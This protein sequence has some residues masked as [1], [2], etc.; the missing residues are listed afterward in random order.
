MKIVV[1][2]LVCVFLL[3]FS[4]GMIS[5]AEQTEDIKQKIN[6]P[7]KAEKETSITGER[8]DLILKVFKKLLDQASRADR[9]DGVEGEEDAGLD[10]LKID[11]I[12]T[13]VDAIK[14]IVQDMEIRLGLV[15]EEIIEAVVDG[16]ESTEDINA[17]DLSVIQWLKAIFYKVR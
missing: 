15:D 8:K 11:E 17:G 6:K 7:T 4:V 2:S 5:A 13:C 1:R 16:L 3:A 9:D 14:A 12:L 10:S